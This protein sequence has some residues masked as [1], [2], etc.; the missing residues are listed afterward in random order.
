MLIRFTTS[1][2]TCLLLV[3]SSLHAAEDLLIEDFEGDSYGDWTVTG[4]AFGLA[5]AKG[6]LPNQMKVSGYHGERLINTFLGGD[7]STGTATSPQF[8]IERSHL[9][10]LIGGGA[11]KDTLGLHLLLDD[12]PVRT[13]TG[14]ESEHLLWASWDVR[15]FKGR[16][17]R[18]RIFD[19]A[20]EGWGHLNVDQI[21]QTD[22]TSN[23]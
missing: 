6:T 15:E 20:T 4:E 16:T 19:N 17:V 10:F 1:F 3:T 11:H 21:I 7:K 5:P 2:L 22:S 14:S 23:T 13:A 8:T 9:V 12:E 18:L